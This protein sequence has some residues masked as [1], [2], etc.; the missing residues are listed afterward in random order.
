MEYDHCISNHWRIA[1]CLSY[2]W[3][4]SQSLNVEAGHKLNAFIA[5]LHVHHLVEC[6]FTKSTNLHLSLFWTQ[7]FYWKAIF[8][9]THL[10]LWPRTRISVPKLSQ[11]SIWEV[12]VLIDDL[13]SKS[14]MSRQRDSLRA[15]PPIS[16]VDGTSWRRKKKPSRHQWSNLEMIIH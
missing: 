13:N 14:C 7:W 2:R 3:K 16:S 9:A 10:F 15:M 5:M 4:V 11:Y 6:H 1:A 12:T 8:L